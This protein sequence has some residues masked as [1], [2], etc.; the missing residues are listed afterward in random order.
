MGETHGGGEAPLTI[1][2]AARLP[3]IA[4]VGRLREARN[5]N[6]E[7]GNATGSRARPVSEKHSTAKAVAKFFT[8]FSLPRVSDNPGV[9]SPGSPIF[10]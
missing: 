5:Q 2:V 7:A 9:D 6:D 3:K 10:S 1:R 8:V 4:P